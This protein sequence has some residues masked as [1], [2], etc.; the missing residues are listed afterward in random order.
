[1]SDLKDCS[2]D[3]VNKCQGK[4][5]GGHAGTIRS[6]PGGL[7]A[8]LT[9]NEGGNEVKFYQ[10]HQENG[11]K[12]LN[13]F[14]PKFGGF[15]IDPETDKKYISVENIKDGFDEPWEMDVK[16]GL[17]SASR[18][19]L[20]GRMGNFRG[21]LKK[22]VHI[23]MDNYFSTSGEYGFRVE[24]F[25]RDKEYQKLESKKM[26]PGHIFKIYFQY[27]TTGKILKNFIKK[28]EEFYKIIM[29][30]GFDNYFLIASSLLFV[31]DKNNAVN[32]NYNVSIKMID[33]D[34]STIADIS[35]LSHSNKHFL[36]VNEYRYGALTLMKELKYY[37]IDR[38]P[39]KSLF[40]RSMLSKSYKSVKNT[41]RK[42]RDDVIKAI[43]KHRNSF[44]TKK[45]Y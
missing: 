25:S 39:D 21:A 33:F 27:D 35:K 37:L 8:K 31:Y 26:L 2:F 16:I 17:R 28:I 11:F 19:E 45:R 29:K 30:D 5:S 10:K 44:T 43:K 40:G 23:L 18:N 20:R 24:N 34:H 3:K 12:D 38:N 32:K 4:N 22:Q 14:I 1:M 42:N 36:R 13:N 15:C 41:K 9:K 6:V 7:C